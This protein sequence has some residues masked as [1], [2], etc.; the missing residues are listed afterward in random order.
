MNKK[1]FFIL[2][3]FCLLFSI[4]ILLNFS[5]VKQTFEDLKGEKIFVISDI[6]NFGVNISDNGFLSNTLTE[7]SFWEKNRVALFTPKGL[8]RR[9]VTSKSLEIHLTDVEQPLGQVVSTNEDGTDYMYQSF[10]M[11]YKDSDARII[12]YVYVHPDIVNTENSFDLAKRF[13][14]LIL[15]SLFDITHPILPEHKD[16]NE[17]LVGKN[18]FINTLSTVARGFFLTIEK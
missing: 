1:L 17:R 7:L 6:G 11:D 2:T 4:F 3:F 8:Q 15:S 12:L 18:D 14:G 16:F 5:L 10:G 9:M 13:S